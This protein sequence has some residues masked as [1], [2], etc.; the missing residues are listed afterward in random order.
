LRTFEISSRRRS[1]AGGAAALLAA[2]I[3]AGAAAA[4]DIDTAV[5]LGTSSNAESAKSQKRVDKID[6][7]T[8]TMARE[9]RTALDQIDS[10]R[11]YNTQ[12]AK[13]IDAQQSEL[14]SLDDQISN[15]TVIGREV[16]PLMLRMLDA[17]EEFIEL[18][19][20]MLI[21]E[22]RERV[23]NLRALM[24]RADVEDSEKYRRLTEAYQVENEY[25][26]TI[27][28]YADTLEIGGEEHT[29]D[30]LRVGRVALLY[31]SRDGK[32]LGAWDQKQRTW[33]RLPDSYRD[34]IRQ[35]I[36]IAS[37]QSAPDLVRIPVSAPEVIR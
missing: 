21:S 24:D 25:G 15:V 27:E 23:A 4:A 17:L 30:F 12:L 32:E 2:W 5:Q 10:L 6:D 26:R 16:T 3:G 35:G 9:Y 36:R 22:R 20:P 34:S 19:I 1:L 28:S 14:A 8:D 11:V 13:L 33:V 7:E 37:K 29:L 18:D 31:M